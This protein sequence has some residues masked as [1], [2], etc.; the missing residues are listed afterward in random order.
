MSCAERAA[1]SVWDAP[2]SRWCR[3]AGAPCVARG[4]RAADRRRVAPCRVRCVTRGGGVERGRN[5][6]RDRDVGH[7]DTRCSAGR[8]PTPAWIP[9]PPLPG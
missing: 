3:L 6:S 2:E 7:R 8:D 1:A 5:G 4:L 9:V